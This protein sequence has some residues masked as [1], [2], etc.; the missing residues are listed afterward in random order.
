M[1]AEAAKIIRELRLAPLPGEGGHFRRVWESAAQVAPGRAASSAILLLLTADDCS[2]L[3][4]LQAEELWQFHA[5]DPVE[6]VMLDPR[7]GA[8]T[9]TLLGPV[10][11]AGRQPQVAVPSGCW[12]GARLQPGAAPRGWALVGCTVT[13]AWRDEEFELGER[14]RLLREFPAAAAWIGGLTR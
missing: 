14:G 3:H 4:R 13:P 11:A 2:A 1:N 10:P 12:Q 7:S 9:V 8:R 5:G 6:H